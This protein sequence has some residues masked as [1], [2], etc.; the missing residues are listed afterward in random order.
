MS[1]H[2]RISADLIACRIAENSALAL[3]VPNVSLKKRLFCK[4]RQCVWFALDMGAK[5]A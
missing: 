4:K 3:G 1:F 2:F 5:R